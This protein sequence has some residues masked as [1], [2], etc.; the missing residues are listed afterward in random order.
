MTCGEAEELITALV[1]GE[2]RGAE[3]ALLEAHLHECADCRSALATERALKQ[4]IR[5]SGTRLRAPVAL[6]TGILSDRRIF[7]EQGRTAK[8][9][10]EHLWP[11]PPVLRPALA[12]AIVLLIALPAYYLADFRREPITVAALETYDLFL[13]G[14]LP[15]RRAEDADEIVAYLSRAVGGRFHPMGYDFSAMDFRPVAGSVR[16]LQGRKILVAIYQGP[17]G[18]IFCYT[19][20]G[21]DDDAPPNAARF[22]DADKK[23]NFY[24]YSRGRI[25]AVFHREGEVIC[26][27]ASQIPMA[28]LLAVTRSKARPS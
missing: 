16:E 6:R 9:W 12:A 7:P 20:L 25:N 18:A 3:R 1:D 15:T 5:D 21:S 22:F 26:I 4:A 2:S 8:G 17:R 11:M 24:A 13:Q 14:N 23:I 27:L 19:F 10:R 28:E